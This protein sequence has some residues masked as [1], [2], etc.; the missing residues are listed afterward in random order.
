VRASPG[1]SPFQRILASLHKR[2]LEIPEEVLANR[3]VGI[4]SNFRDPHLGCPSDVVEILRTSRFVIIHAAWEVNFNLPLA[5]FEVEVIASTK[6]LLDL[7]LSVRKPGQ[8]PGRFVFV[9]SISTAT[10]SPSRIIVSESQIENLAH[11]QTT[12]YARSKLVAE[13]IAHNAAVTAGA[14]VRV[15][16]IGQIVGD[17]RNGVWNDDEAIPLMIRSAKDIGALPQLQEKCSWLPVDQCAAAILELS[18]LSDGLDS[19]AASWSGSGSGSASLL[20]YNVLHPVSFDWTDDL[21][22]ALRRAGMQ[23]N[24]VPPREW[25]RLLEQC[26][27]VDPKANPSI[28]LLGFWKDRYERRNEGHT[29]EVVK[30]STTI[31]ER[32]SVS[33]REA[34]DCISSGLVERFVQRWMRV[35]GSA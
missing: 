33:L 14:D 28:K 31:A 10:G 32:D 25:V 11:A 16:R 17:S 22:P 5:S 30:F 13:H 34:Q 23:F 8:Q 4:T 26:H 3:V 15:L 6:R 2:C 24:A 9:S 27:D 7:S 12:G 1:Q 20:Y 21:L 18:G 19:K 35:W 29:A